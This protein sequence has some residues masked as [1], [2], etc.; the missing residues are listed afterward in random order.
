MVIGEYNE[1]G[2]VILS[3]KGGEARELYSAGNHPKDST[4]HESDPAFALTLRQ[5]RSFCIQSAKELAKERK[6]KYAG[7][8][9][10]EQN[11]V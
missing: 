6:E 3:L 5:L 9:R 8:E 1:D 2:Y 7:V 10:I 4:Q 11:V